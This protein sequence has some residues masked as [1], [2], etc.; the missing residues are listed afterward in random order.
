MT[1]SKQPTVSVVM[2]VYNGERFLREAV[3]SVLA[4]TYPD[5]ELVIIDDGSTDHSEEIIRS[6]QDDRIHFLQNEKNMGLCATQNKVIAAA[7]GKYIAVMDCDDISYPNR[8]MEQVAYLDE[9]P[10]TMMC[11]TFRKDIVDGEEQFF[12]EPVQLDNETLQFSLVF[13]NFFFTHSSIMFR[14]KEYRDNKL[15]YGPATIAEDYQIILEMA[16]RYP[17]AMI[18]KCLVGYRIDMQSISHVKE[19]E[20]TEA[21]CRVKTDYLESLPLEDWVKDVLR[22][23]FLSG[24]ATEAVEDFIKSMEAIAKYTDADVSC[25]GNAHGVAC[26]ILR[27]YVLRVSRYCMAT[28]RQLRSSQYKEIVSLKSLFGWRI[29]VM[30]LLGYRREQYAK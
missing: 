4:Q 3:D 12:H 9:H 14:A 5:F 17:I 7:R 25:R 21:A 13:G 20:I 28:W 29:L 18:P 6:Y 15:S 24:V 26:D 27:E 16:K 2:K 22:D 23:Y 11:G 1:E 8:L 10:E 19:K 30:C